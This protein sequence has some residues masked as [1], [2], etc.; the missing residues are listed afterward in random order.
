MLTSGQRRWTYSSRETMKWHMS[1]TISKSIKSLSAIEDSRCWFRIRSLATFETVAVI[2]WFS[3]FQSYVAQPDSLTKCAQISR[4]WKQWP[5]THRWIPRNAESVYLNSHAEYTEC[6][7]A[8]PHSP[9]IILTSAKISSGSRD[10][11]CVK[12]WC[13]SAATKREDY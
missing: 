13:S 2:R 11:R 7:T 3:W 8:A 9:D 4:W 12:N 6:K 5:N 1:I 10:V